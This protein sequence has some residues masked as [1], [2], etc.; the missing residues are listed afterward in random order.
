MGFEVHRIFGFV[1]VLHR[2]VDL[3]NRFSIFG[4]YYSYIHFFAF[5]IC[6]L[7]RNV[8]L[9]YH[10]IINV[11]NSWFYDAKAHEHPRRG[12]GKTQAC[13]SSG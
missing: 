6:F 10:Q 1:N 7:F 2:F 9:P 12:T 8:P 13:Q 4:F 11:N 5:R 3:C